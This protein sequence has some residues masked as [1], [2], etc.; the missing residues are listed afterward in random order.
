MGFSNLQ[1]T[2]SRS[3]SIANISNATPP[4]SAFPSVPAISTR[5]WWKNRDSSWCAALIGRQG[6]V[7]TSKKGCRST[8]EFWFG[9]VNPL[10]R[11]QDFNSSILFFRPTN[12][13]EADCLFA[14]FNLKLS[15]RF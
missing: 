4:S 14:E 9:S 10:I 11:N 1:V 6:T 7:Q 13:D 3:A 8:P 15:A 12:R 2:V 5:G